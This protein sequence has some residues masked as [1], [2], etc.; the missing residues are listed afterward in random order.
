L[1]TKAVLT[2][3]ICQFAFYT[4]AA[5]SVVISL[6]LTA[7]GAVYLRPVA[8]LGLGVSAL[9]LL[10]S[11]GYLYT[12]QVKLGRE[13]QPGLTL[14]LMLAIIFPS[15]LILANAR[16]TFEAFFGAPMDFTPTPKAGGVCLTAWR[17]HQ[18]LF[19]GLF[20]PLF[21]L[22]EHAWSAPF[23]VF[24]AAGLLSIGAMG[25]STATQ[26]PAPQTVPANSPN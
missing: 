23:F 9:G 4:L 17:G 7:V 12:G 18:E 5:L 26:A 11:L 24:A 8:E 20:L 15:G 16:A 25:R 13:D 21:A 22:A 1:W 6:A 19:A 10:T 3:Q 14:S 2:L